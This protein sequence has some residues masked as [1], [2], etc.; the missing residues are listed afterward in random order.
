MQITT[1]IYLVLLAIGIFCGFASIVLTFYIGKRHIKEVDRIALGYE[2]D[3]D[4]IFNLMLRIPNY[5]LAFVW[6]LYAKR[7]GLLE[8]RKI[9]DKKFKRPFMVNMWLLIVG[10]SAFG[11]DFYLYKFYFQ[12]GL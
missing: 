3:K 5:T 10:G 6:P 9:F 11:I 1:I 4:S 12:N 7:G 8:L 2:I